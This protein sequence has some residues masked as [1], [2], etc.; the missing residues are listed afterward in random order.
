MSITT[1]TRQTAQMGMPERK[2]RALAMQ[3]G[4]ATMRSLARASRV[5]RCVLADAIRGRT[6]PRETTIARVAHVLG[7]PV[8]VLADLFR[9]A[10]AERSS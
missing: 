9:A 1:T 4:Y 10:R 5:D 3:R 8:S 6:T 7:A 2:L